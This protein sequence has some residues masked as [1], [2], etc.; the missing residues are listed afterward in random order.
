MA[1]EYIQDLKLRSDE[2]VIILGIRRANGTYVGAPTGE[3]MI[4]AGNTVIAYGTES[5]LQKI[6]ERTKDEELASNTYDPTDIRNQ[7][8]IR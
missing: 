4:R 7:F 2:N 6:A 5:R 3:D 1:N 8:D